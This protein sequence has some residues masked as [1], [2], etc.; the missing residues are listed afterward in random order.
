MY[1]VDTYYA[2]VD[3]AFILY[4]VVFYFV[5]AI[6]FKKDIRKCVHNMDI[7][8]CPKCGKKLNAYEINRLWC[9]DC[10]AKF[11]SI[12]DLYEK[13]PDF[14][15]ENELRQ[16]LYKD[17]LITTGHQFEGYNIIKYLRFF[18]YFLK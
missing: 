9:T 12:Q 3:N 16:K 17:F 15:Q 4:K 5:Y 18:I 1:V 10:N 14:K 6:I 13:N 8:I 2:L 11:Q 7:I